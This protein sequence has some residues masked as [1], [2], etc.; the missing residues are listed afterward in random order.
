MNTGAMISFSRRAGHSLYRRNNRLRLPFPREAVRARTADV[1]H[2]RRSEAREAGAAD[3]PDAC[4]D[5]TERAGLQQALGEPLR[6]D[7]AV[8]TEAG[9][10]AARTAQVVKGRA[11]IGEIVVIG[12]GVVEPSD[13]SELHG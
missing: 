6:H 9:A 10:E 11:E 8:G 7:V 4:V 5:H 3:M 1:R 2:E 12:D 13:F